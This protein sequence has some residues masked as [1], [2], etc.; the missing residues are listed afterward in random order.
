MRN[1]YLI[2]ATALAL[3]SCMHEADKSP[4][5]PGAAYRVTAALEA[6]VSTKGNIA[7][8]TTLD[9]FSWLIARG[10]VLLYSGSGEMDDVYL[11]EN[12]T[13]TVF[14]WANTGEDYSIADAL[15]Q[16]Y[17]FSSS[18]ASWDGLHIPSSYYADNISPAELDALDGSV[19]GNIRL[20][21]RRLTAK[22]QLSI[23]FDDM[24]RTMFPDEPG[25]YGITVNSVKLGGVA[26]SVGVFTPEAN[27]RGSSAGTLDQNSGTPDYV[28]YV[29]ESL[30][31]ELLAGNSNPSNKNAQSLAALGLNPN[32]Y[33]YVEVSITF[34][35]YM[36]STPF[37]KIYRFYLGANST[38][39]F[40]VER[41]REYNVTLLLGYD[42]LDVND[43]W[44]LDGE[45]S[46]LDGR[47]CTVDCNK[48]R[49]AP[50]EKVVLST[51]YQY[52]GSGNVAA[53]FYQRQNGFAL[54]QGAEKDAY[55]GTGAIPQGFTQLGDNGYILECMEC[56]HYYTG[57]PVSSGNARML[58]LADN[59]TCN[60]D[61]VNCTWCGAHLF[62]QHFNTDDWDLFSHSAS[63]YIGTNTS[64]LSQFSNDF[65]YTIPADAHLGDV[66]RIYAVTR[67]GR[68]GSHIDITVSNE[69]G[70]PHFV[71]SSGDDM[72]VA[73]KGTLVASRWAE[74]IYGS[75]PSFS[76]SI[77][78]RDGLGAADSGVASLSSID[79]KSV[80]I[81]AKKPGTFTVTCTYNG[82]DAGTYDGIISAPGIGY[83]SGL[84]GFTVKN[85]G[86]VTSI[87]KPVYLIQDGGNWV[88]YTSYDETLFAS[89]LGG[90]DCSL[91]E[92]NGWVGL[93]GI[94]LYLN[95][96][97]KNGVVSTQNLLPYNSPSTRLD[98]LR[99]TSSRLAGPY[100][101]VPVYF[102]GRYTRIRLINDYGTY[103]KYIADEG[104]IP[105]QASPSFNANSVWPYSFGA[106]EFFA[107]ING[108]PVSTSQVIVSNGNGNY[109][110]YTG[111]LGQRRLYWRLKG[112][113]NDSFQLDI[114][115]ITVKQKYIGSITATC[116]ADDTSTKTNIYGGFASWKDSPVGAFNTFSS[117][118][119]SSGT[120]Q[121]F[122]VYVGCRNVIKELFQLQHR[123]FLPT[124]GVYDPS[125]STASNIPN[126][127]NF[128]H[129][130]RDAVFY[131]QAKHI[132]D[133]DN[134]S[135]VAV[136][137]RWAS[138]YAVLFLRTIETNGFG[139]EKYKSFNAP[140]FVPATSPQTISG[141]T[142]TLISDD[143]S[144][145]LWSS[146]LK[147]CEF[148]YANWNQ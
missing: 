31:G 53:D 68:A 12:S 144:T 124:E 103:Y 19:D 128:Y 3:C 52:D 118:E 62:R 132:Y 96:A 61:D 1:T 46:A 22:L 72:W 139:I 140:L 5:Q 20:P 123:A 81:S 40:D 84:S 69:C 121:G 76:F 143:G 29:P 100:C 92:D 8:D 137:A 24:L 125:P 89:C 108:T 39:N 117:P 10:D 90:I 97:Y 104:L 35:A 119:V 99:F 79:T 21:L 23:A 56:H 6:P 11:T 120:L 43:T 63:T 106:D 135:Y 34:S 59:L 73:Q 133:D 17:S 9:S 141:E 2:C 74:G 146:G 147:E 36:V 55:I 98:M 87:T 66:L 16:M 122:R 110:Y 136:M 145:A 47:S 51:C 60:D 113:S 58:W 80:Y 107:E 129:N 33:P 86:V 25:G 27:D 49:A 127:W 41:N 95:H 28:F 38:S 111:S 50:G 45:T 18:R 71:N 130:N 82:K 93:D 102:D 15:S 67:D 75:N 131:T 101:D 105:A 7:D 48:L 30:G 142:W 115:R 4:E 109:T 85:N 116:D 44:K 94:D 32:A 91:A 14:A 64:C 37:T 78:C 114:C 148:K 134:L 83:T 57:M 88:E 70:Y 65:E 77:S 54:C 112:S 13:Y 26:Q 138:Y 42:G 126:T